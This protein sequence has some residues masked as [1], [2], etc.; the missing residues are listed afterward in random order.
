MNGPAYIPVSAPK[1]WGNEIEHIARALDSGWVSGM[2][3]PVSRFEQA[4]AGYIGVP[5]GV[6]VSSGTCALQIALRAVGTQSGDEVIVPDFSI[7]SPAFAAVACGATV[8]PVDADASWNID[9]DKVE[10][11]M[12][13]RTRAIVVVHTYGRPAQ[14]ER[15]C[16]IARR[17]RIA[18]I[19]DAAEC[20]G[21]RVG[22]FGDA[23]CL[24]LSTLSGIES[25]TLFGMFGLLARWRAGEEPTDRR[26]MNFEQPRRVGSRFVALGNHLSDLRLLLGGQL[27]AASAYPPFLAS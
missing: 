17:R 26:R 7:I 5:H 15:L 9:P 20:L 25:S 6:A 13:P 22:S 4:F 24:S 14:I 8:V 19:E 10:A 23:A 16:K 27:G 2:G 18:L 12:S 3:E 21:G 11:A 1:L